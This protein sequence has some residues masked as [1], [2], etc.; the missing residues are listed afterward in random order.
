MLITISFP[1][2]GS[3]GQQKKQL[4]PLGT[5]VKID[6]L[7]TPQIGGIKQVVSIETDDTNRPVLLFLAGGPGSS[8]M[9]NADAFTNQLK[10]KFTIV[11]WDQRDAYSTSRMI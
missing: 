7:L 11:H 9:N 6:T 4:K 1:F 3:N 10:G 2:Y 8:M 5:A